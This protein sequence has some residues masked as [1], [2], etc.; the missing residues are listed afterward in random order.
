MGS[1]YPWNVQYIF[2]PMG[3]V[4]NICCT[5]VVV[6]CM[7]VSWILR[8]REASSG[9]FMFFYKYPQTVSP[10]VTNTPAISINGAMRTLTQGT[11]ARKI[12]SLEPPNS[13]RVTSVC[14]THRIFRSKLSNPLLAYPRSVSTECLFRGSRLLQ[15]TAVCWSRLIG[16]GSRPSRWRWRWR[17]P[18]QRPLGR[19][20]PVGRPSRHR[21]ESSCLSVLSSPVEIQH[22]WP[23]Y[24]PRRL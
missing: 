4:F 20:A 7:H 12:E 19:S 6:E 9:W 23:S 17:R 13:V 8:T 14:F 3:N 16:R 2:E 1:I 22:Q 10:V 21:S 18:P 24:P 15:S 11:W 5:S